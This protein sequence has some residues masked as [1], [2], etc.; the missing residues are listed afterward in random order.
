MSNEIIHSIAY[1]N[2]HNDDFQRLNFIFSQNFIS[3]FWGLFNDETDL[4]VK[5][6]EI[7]H[8][9]LLLLE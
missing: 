9:N 3:Q 7:G 5:Y 6:L 2:Y 1:D 8:P 4:R